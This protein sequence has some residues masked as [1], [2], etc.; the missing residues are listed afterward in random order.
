MNKFNVSGYFGSEEHIENAKKASILGIEK[1]QELK[2]ER[3][4]EYNSNPKLCKYCNEPLQYGDNRKIFC[5]SSCAASYNNKHKTKGNRRSK[6]EMF[7]EQKLKLLYPNLEIL[8]NDK[9]T[10]GSELDIYIPSLKLAF[11]LNG[12]YHFEPIHG[13]K[14]LESIHK[15]DINKFESCQKNLISLCVIDTSKQTYFKESTSKIYLDIIID[16]ITS[17]L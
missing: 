2:K 15:N 4:D 16:I 13:S 9:L 10:I 5:N 14:K 8:F 1:I 11:E 17:L 3:I 12:I 6:L 7:I